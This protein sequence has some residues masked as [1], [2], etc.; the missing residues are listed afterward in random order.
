[1]N[2]RNFIKFGIVGAGTALAGVK[3]LQ[4]EVASS[5]PKSTA[6]VVG[7]P[8]SVAPLAQRELDPLF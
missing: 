6:T 7:M 1:M 5:P 4:G 8:I 2:R 3:T